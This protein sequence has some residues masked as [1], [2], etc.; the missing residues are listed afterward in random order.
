[1]YDRDRSKR[2][3]FWDAELLLRSLWA[4]YHVEELPVHWVCRLDSRFMLRRQF[5]ILPYALR[6]LAEERVLPKR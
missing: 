6:L 3:W 1:M 5:R 4:G 2:A